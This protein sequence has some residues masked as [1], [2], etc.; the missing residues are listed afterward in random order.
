LRGGGISRNFQIATTTQAWQRNMSYNVQNAHVHA[1]QCTKCTCSFSKHRSKY[2]R[3]CDQKPILR[4]LNL[5]CYVFF[6]IPNFRT[7]NFRTSLYQISNKINIFELSNFRTTIILNCQ[8]S[9]ISNCQT[10]KLSNKQSVDIVEHSTTFW[11]NPT[12][13]IVDIVEHSTTFR[14]N[15]NQLGCSFKWQFC[16]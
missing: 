1:I 4:L 3:Q 5:Q 8:I 6:R 7:P 9:E 13:Q 11:T 15:P 12:K 10:V 14:T 16:P 2:C